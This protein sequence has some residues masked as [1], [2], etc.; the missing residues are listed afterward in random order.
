MLLTVVAHFSVILCSGQDGQNAANSNAIRMG[1]SGGAD[2]QAL[3]YARMCKLQRNKAVQAHEISYIGQ[4]CSDCEIALEGQLH[5]PD[6]FHCMLR[7]VLA[8]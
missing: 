6:I 2:H 8:T 4:N 5:D 3:R 7:E 1:R